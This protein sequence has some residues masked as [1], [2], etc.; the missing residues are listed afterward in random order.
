MLMANRLCEANL[1]FLILGVTAITSAWS[2]L[3]GDVT[4]IADENRL[5][6]ISHD[7]EGPLP[8]LDEAQIG[9]PVAVDVDV[10]MHFVFWIDGLADKI[11]KASLDGIEY[12]IIASTSDSPKMMSI[13]IDAKLIFWTE[14]DTDTIKSVN[15][16]GSDQRTV[17]SMPNKDPV[18]VVVDMARRVLYWST[19]ARRCSYY[20]SYY[21]CRRYEEYRHIGKV[22]YDGANSEILVEESSDYLPRG[23]ALNAEGT[24]LYWC[25]YDDSDGLINVIKSL[26]LAEEEPSTFAVHSASCWGVAWFEDEVTWVDSRRASLWEKHVNRSTSTQVDTQEDLTAPLDVFRGHLTPQDMENWHCDFTYGQ[27]GWRNAKVNE[28]DWTRQSGQMA[29]NSSGG[30]EVDHT[31]R[32]ADGRYMFVDTL[33]GAVENQIATL[34]SPPVRASESEPLCFR[35]WYHMNNVVNGSLKVFFQPEDDVGEY[36]Q[37]EAHDN[38]DHGP[39]QL[40]R[41]VFGGHLDEWIGGEAEV[42][43]TGFGRILLV[44]TVGDPEANEVAVDGVSYGK[45]SEATRLT[46]GATS[47]TMYLDRARLGI[48]SD[49]EITFLDSDCH[50]VEHDHDTISITTDYNDC[51][52]VPTEHEDYITFSNKVHVRTGSG[53]RN[54]DIDIKLNCS[55][56]RNYRVDM[57]YLSHAW[58]KFVKEDEYGNFSVMIRQFHDEGFGS[59]F[60]FNSYPQEVAESDN[61]YIATEMSFVADVVE[62][63]NVRCWATESPDPTDSVRHELIVEGCPVDR[64]VRVFP[65][66]NPSVQPFS[67]RGFSFGGDLELVYVHCD[68][69][70]CHQSDESACVTD[71]RSTSRRQRR[72]SRMR[73]EASSGPHTVSQGPFVFRRARGG[74]PGIM[75]SLLVVACACVVLLLAAVVALLRTRNHAPSVGV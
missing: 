58:L 10:D 74:S 66:P 50:G 29:A 17:L 31:S 32:T 62:S 4:V 43:A 35:Y 42:R 60:P 8:L 25:S 68:V 57:S 19:S 15:Y 39:T 54:S 12:E 75:S 72:E 51:G 70:V 64:S 69:I 7:Y 21:R 37:Y 5:Y 27:C 26:D 40:L 2:H 71:C 46:C 48:L 56:G 73:R 20:D 36:L 53:I 52:T 33:H 47:M 61:I 16:D 11:K 24:V 6:L 13:D 65:S 23:L 49:D 30:P 44:V 41:S 22:D 3:S 9:N 18:G 67:F 14:I 55:M 63:K 34:V 28:V 38:H 1:F 59:P 45:C